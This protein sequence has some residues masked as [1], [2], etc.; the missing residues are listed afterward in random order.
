MHQCVK[1]VER[2]VESNNVEPDNTESEN[3]ESE[4]IESDKLLFN[5]LIIYLFTYENCVKLV[6][7]Y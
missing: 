6:L 4:N 2:I 5:Y 1:N 7:I 3:T